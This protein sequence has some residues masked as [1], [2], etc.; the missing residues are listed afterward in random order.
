MAR[1]RKS[2]LR[3]ADQRTA[4]GLYRIRFYENYGHS[5]AWQSVPP[6]M[7]HLGFAPQPD[8]PPAFADSCVVAIDE[9]G[10]VLGFIVYDCG[11]KSW[12]ITLSY[13]DLENRPKNIQTS[14]LTALVNKAQEK[15]VPVNFFTHVNNLAAHNL[16][17]MRMPE[18]LVEHFDASPD[19][20]KSMQ[21]FINEK[22]AE[23]YALH[24]AIERS[25]YQWVLIF[26]RIAAE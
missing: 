8:L 20:L 23:G 19:G 5:P 15:G 4:K 6:E 24:Q 9:D 25:T 13:V 1:S 21:A 7:A 22:A 2:V 18:Y 16:G 14:L 11:E 3:Q 10:N 12:D 17:E 26:R